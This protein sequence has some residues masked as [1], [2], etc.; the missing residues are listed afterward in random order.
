MSN[1]QSDEIFLVDGSGYI[2]RASVNVF[3]VARVALRPHVS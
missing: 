1:A 3:N 2:F